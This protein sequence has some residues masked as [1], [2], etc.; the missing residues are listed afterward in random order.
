[1]TGGSDSLCG[2]EMSPARLTSLGKWYVNLST[3]PPAKLIQLVASL[4]RQ[5]MLLKSSKCNDTL[6]QLTL[7]MLYSKPLTELE[8]VCPIRLS[9]L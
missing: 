9:Y 7:S 3:V 5:H 1:M 2:R 4:A 6:L 8:Y